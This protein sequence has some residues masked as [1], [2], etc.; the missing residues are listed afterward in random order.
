MYVY[1]RVVNLRKSP[2]IAAKGADGSN[3]KFSAKVV[4]VHPEL[5]FQALFLQQPLFGRLGDNTPVPLVSA[6]S[7]QTH[8]VVIS[9]RC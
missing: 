9:H 3:L 5:S 2:E 7:K 1:G 6:N 8:K 4:E